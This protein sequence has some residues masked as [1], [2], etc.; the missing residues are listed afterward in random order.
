MHLDLDLE[1]TRDAPARVCAAIVNFATEGIRNALKHADCT[2]VTAR[3][4]LESGLLRLAIEN[5]G[6]RPARSD[7]GVGLR[8][9][10]LDADRLGGF[11]TAKP[12]EEKWQLILTLPIKQ[13]S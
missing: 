1:A 9:L 3:A 10:E 12:M 8:L 11:L 7:P 13:P 6:V 2:Y 5:D 4:T